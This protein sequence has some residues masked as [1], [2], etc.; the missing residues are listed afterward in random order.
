M[1]FVYVS[2]P[3]KLGILA[4]DVY[5]QGQIQSGD[6]QVARHLAY[7]ISIKGFN[8]EICLA[9]DESVGLRCSDA[10][11]CFQFLKHFEIIE[12]T[13]GMLVIIAPTIPPTIAAKTV[14]Y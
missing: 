3:R 6:V 8:V 1:I 4:S 10:I 5:Q 14:E 11:Y 7:P 2:F 9:C 13:N 12:N